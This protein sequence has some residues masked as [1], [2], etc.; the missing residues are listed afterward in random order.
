MK[1]IESIENSSQ[2]TTIQLLNYNE[3]EIRFENKKRTNN[4][5]ETL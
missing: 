3:F 5:L 4:K 2:Q 1:T